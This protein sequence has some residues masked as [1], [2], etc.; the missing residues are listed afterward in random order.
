[1]LGFLL[2]VYIYNNMNEARKQQKVKLNQVYIHKLEPFTDQEVELIRAL[3]GMPKKGLGDWEF[4]TPDDEYYS[5]KHLNAYTKI[6]QK[7]YDNT[8]QPEPELNAPIVGYR[9]VP[10]MAEYYVFKRE[11]KFYTVAANKFEYSS[12]FI[13]GDFEIISKIYEFNDLRKAIAFVKKDAK[14]LSTENPLMTGYQ[15]VQYKLTENELI[16]PYEADE[17]FE[18]FGVKN[19]MLLSKDD[20]KKAFRSLAIKH[21]PDKGGKEED[22]KQI[23]AAYESLLVND[24]SGK[25][26]GTTRIRKPTKQDYEDP[27]AIN[28]L[29]DLGKILKNK[30]TS[31]NLPIKGKIG[32]SITS[33]QGGWMQVSFFLTNGEVG[34][35]D[36]VKRG[37][38]MRVHDPIEETDDNIKEFALNDIDGV[39]AHIVA[40]AKSRVPVQIGKS[41]RTKK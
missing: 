37:N 21:H 20:L 40:T 10:G 3:T 19:A 26:G 27:T 1:M 6:L 9:R 36:I 18:K 14:T 28:F 38:K 7:W 12:W 22:M 33:F 11:G 4:H 31:K 29:D 35:F 41:S 25:S 23:N 13:D 16:S 32:I 2:C 5:K 8:D 17:I 24:G 39:V 30:L 34:L 15:N